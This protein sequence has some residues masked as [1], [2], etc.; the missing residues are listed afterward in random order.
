VSRIVN[1]AK[2]G[3]YQAVSIYSD[4]HGS[5]WHAGEPVGTSM[6]ENK[7][8]ELSDGTVMMNSRDSNGSGYRKVAYS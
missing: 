2:G 5:T 3:A 1:E 4:D 8:V 7:T 6:D